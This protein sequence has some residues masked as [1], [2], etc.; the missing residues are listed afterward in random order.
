MWPYIL[1]LYPKNSSLN[2]QNVIL[3]KEGKAYENILR[4]WK[5][6]ESQHYH[7]NDPTSTSLAIRQGITTSSLMKKSSSPTTPN[8]IEL[9]VNESHSGSQMLSS[10][11]EADDDDS[12][13]EDLLLMSDRPRTSGSSDGGLDVNRGVSEE[14]MEQSEGEEL[15]QRERMF[16]DELY[17]IDKDIPRCD[18]DYRYILSCLDS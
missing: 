6:I 11:E 7:N 13:C 16:L 9:D 10:E 5:A 4:K 1:G 8:L 3:L 12:G 18:R 15:S 17:K 2:E 14:G